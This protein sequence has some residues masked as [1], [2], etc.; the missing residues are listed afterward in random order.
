MSNILM[1]EECGH[2]LTFVE[3]IPDKL[4]LYECKNCNDEFML[5]DQKE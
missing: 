3:E 4:W 2:E 5:T 1:C